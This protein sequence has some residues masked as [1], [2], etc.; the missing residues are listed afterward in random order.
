MKKLPKEFARRAAR[1][2]L[3]N[4]KAF[5]D[6]ADALERMTDLYNSVCQKDCTLSTTGG[7]LFT[8]DPEGDI[9]MW[10]SPNVLWEAK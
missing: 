5:K 3:M 6:E 4:P 2:A 9:E 1:I 7:V 10:V 8:K